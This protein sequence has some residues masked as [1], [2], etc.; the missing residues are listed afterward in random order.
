MARVIDIL[1]K[2]AEQGLTE[3][4][5]H[6]ELQY[7][8]SGSEGARNIQGR[9]DFFLALGEVLEGQ[10]SLRKNCW[11]NPLFLGT[12]CPTPSIQ[13]PSTWIPH[14]G[15]PLRPCCTPKM[16]IMLYANYN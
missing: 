16:N 6:T 4:L 5:S 14:P 10:L 1:V 8:D 9:T 7:W 11:Q 2:K 3:G 13:S 12:A 15:D